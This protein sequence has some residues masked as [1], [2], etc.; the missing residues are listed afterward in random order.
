MIGIELVK[1]RKTKEEFSYPD[2]MGHKVAPGGARPR[3]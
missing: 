1:D 3:G 2:R